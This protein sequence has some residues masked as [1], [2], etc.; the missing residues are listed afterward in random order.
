MT[1]VPNNADFE[2][3][4]AASEQE[5]VSD[6]HTLHDRH[7][8]PFDRTVSGLAAA[9]AA[10]QDCVNNLQRALAGPVM[11]AAL[12]LILGWQASVKTLDDPGGTH[13]DTGTL[14]LAPD[15]SS[16]ALSVAQTNPA[17]AGAAPG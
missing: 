4:V 5:H 14:T 11:Q 3:R 12:G 16:A 1:A 10:P 7:I 2:R 8:V 13:Q 9:G 17:V 6:L 15:C